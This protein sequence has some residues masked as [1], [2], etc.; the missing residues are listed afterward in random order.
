MRG[1]FLW[2][3]S[4][5]KGPLPSSPPVPQV[6]GQNVVKVGHRQVVSMI[7][8]GGNT[9]MVKVVMVTRHPDMDEAVHKKGACFS[10]HLA[11]HCHQS[12]SLRTTD[13]WSPLLTS[14]P[15]PRLLVPNPLGEK[16]A[17]REGS[18]AEVCC[19]WSSGD[20]VEVGEFWGTSPNGADA[21][22]PNMDFSAPQQAKRLPPPTISLRSKSMT[23]E[24]EEMG[25][26][27]G[28]LARE[29]KERGAGPFLQFVSV[30]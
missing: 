23:S 4:K 14:F 11:P 21:S 2:G 27:A 16:Q 22:H 15:S 9:L 8:Q 20:T 18:D 12:K 7:R 29:G 26:C 10:S 17:W 3:D 19:S 30:C 13:G 28:L 5:P 25:E 6:N 24:L 1:R